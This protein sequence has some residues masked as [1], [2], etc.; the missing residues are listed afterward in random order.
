MRDL[1][2]DGESEVTLLLNWDGT[3]CCSWSRVYRYDRARRRYVPA[4]HFWGNAAAIPQLRDLD[5]DR[6]PEFVSRDDRFT[7]VFTSYAGSVTPIQVW[8][9]RRGR[10]RDVTRRY[11]AQVRRDAVRLW[12]LYLKY[13]PRDEARGILP[14]WAADEY[15]LGRGAVADE[16]LEAAAARGQLKAG[17]FEEPRDQRAYISAVKALLRRTGYAR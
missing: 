11:P 16:A 7:E 3:H 9:Y 6:R 10:F 14:A 1:D 17:A 5:G 4:N 15:L 12:R 13:G 2:G 8:S